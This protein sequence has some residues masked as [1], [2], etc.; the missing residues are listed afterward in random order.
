MDRE[1]LDALLS[2]LEALIKL[3]QADYKVFDEIQEVL[4]E[5]KVLLELKK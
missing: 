4:N 3:K 1:R 5:I 2:Y